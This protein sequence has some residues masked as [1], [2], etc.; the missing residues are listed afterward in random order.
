LLNKNIFYIFFV[1]SGVLFLLLAAG[2]GGGVGG[3]NPPNENYI[4]TVRITPSQVIEGEEVLC[5]AEIS[6]APPSG[7]EIVWEQDPSSP[8][9]SFSPPKGSTTHWISPE[10]EKSQSFSLIASFSLMGKIYSGS[11]VVL[12]LEKGSPPQ[13]PPSLT[14]SYPSD[15]Q[16]VGSGTLLTIIGNISQGSN[17]LRELQ[18]LD[19]ETIL[20]K[21][22]VTPGS[23]RVDLSNFGSPGRKVIKVR[24]T[25]SVGLYGEQT[26]TVTNDNSLL[27]EEARE[28]LKK[29]SCTG[30]GTERF[31]DLEDGPYSKP[32]RIFI[33]STELKQYESLIKEA[34]DFWTK[35]CGIAFQ[36]YEYDGS[37]IDFPYILLEAKFDED[38]G[39][40]AQTRRGYIGNKIVAGYITLYKGWVD[41]CTSEARIVVLEH[42]IGHGL[43]TSQEVTDP[44]Y[45]NVMWP[46][47]DAN[48]DILPPVMQRAT[49]LLYEWPPGT[50]P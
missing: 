2:C 31:G 8:P 16:V 48:C 33:V 19:S 24:V 30:G 37:H 29:Y 40:V 50:K 46:Y 22:S 11:G 32:V 45:P 15:E 9:G 36:I 43:L 5:E 47:P 25:D 14:I 20:Q 1:F 23:F 13:S 49:R 21:W 41:N 44:G 39:V 4:I 3:I 18:V 27:D 6:P 28:F 38:P 17:P 34:T 7:V 12:V 10:V 35:Y 26:I 42:E